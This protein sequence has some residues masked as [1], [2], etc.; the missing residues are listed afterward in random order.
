MSAGPSPNLLAGGTAPQ[1]GLFPRV[2]ALF[3]RHPVL[4]LLL[5]A[6]QVEYLTGSSQLYL[7]VASPLVFLFFLLQ[8]M[9]SYGLAVLLIREAK[10]RWKLGWASVL[11]LGAV[12]GLLNEG[13]GA[14]TLF[15]PHEMVFGGPMGYGRW[16]GI[17]WVTA[18]ELIV[19]VHPLFSVSLPV[20]EFDLA[21]PTL[22]GKT[23]ITL[24]WTRG[25]LVLLAVDGLGTMVLV[26]AFLRHYW[27]SPFLLVAC[28]ALMGSLVLAAR[29][30]PPHWLR[31]PLSTPT[32]PPWAFFVLG[33]GLFWGI[34]FGSGVLINLV[35]VPW[36]VVASIVGMAGLA[37]YWVVHHV[38]RTNHEL[39]LLALAVGSVFVALAPQG[40]FGQL[41]SGPGMVPVV[42]YDLVI[43]LFFT[44]LYLTHRDRGHRPSTLPREG[45]RDLGPERSPLT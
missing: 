15:N 23:L 44:H 35:N 34:S 3:R 6:P 10:V 13:I 12:Y 16:L 43:A 14:A 9:G 2:R 20:M 17:N 32:A 19:F 11:L 18:V 30:A 21:F 22:R 31:P 36:V 40:F 38:G 41:F 5:L 4:F 39:H 24:P 28:G 42:A 29:W 25:A 37:L 45:G 1:G 33:A 26:S 7:L 8:N 27:V